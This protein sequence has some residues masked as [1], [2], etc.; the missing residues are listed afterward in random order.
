MVAHPKLT[1]L[2]DFIGRT[3]F[4]A[5]DIELQTK[6]YPFRPGTASNPTNAQVQTSTTNPI[7]GQPGNQLELLDGNLSLL[8][9]A[10]VSGTTRE[11]T[12]S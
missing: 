1:L 12:C 3:Q 9:G 8:L 7:T 2:A 5:G 4:N 6:T 11:Q 10:W